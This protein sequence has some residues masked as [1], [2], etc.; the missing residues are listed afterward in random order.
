M[1]FLNLACSAASLQD[2]REQAELIPSSVELVLLTAG[3]IDAKAYPFLISCIDTPCDA[4]LPGMLDSLEAMRPNMREVLQL[5][6]SNNRKVL[7]SGY[8]PVF[9]PC[10][11]FDA[12]A[13][14]NIAIAYGASRRMLG[15]VTADLRAEGFDVTLL[16]HPLFDETVPCEH[17]NVLYPDVDSLLRLHPTAEGYKVM[18]QEALAYLASAS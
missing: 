5:L 8:P 12:R 17:L 2:V 7:L 6:A 3:G 10:R 11:A 18:A 4:E 15:E 1:D 13:L 9:P 14:E 16:E